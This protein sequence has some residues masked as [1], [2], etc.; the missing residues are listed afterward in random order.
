MQIKSARSQ[1]LHTR[2]FDINNLSG[3]LIDL[4]LVFLNL[5]I[6]VIFVLETYPL[7]P[8]FKNLLWML[9]VFTICFFILEYILRFYTSQNRLRYFFSIYSF[10]DLLVIIPTLI[11]FAFPDSQAS[12]N[13]RVLYLLRGFKVFRIF[14]F[15]R[16]LTDQYFFFGAISLSFLKVLRLI[17]TIIMIFFFGSGVFYYL[18]F[19]NNPG[20]QN[21]GDAFYFC[22]VTLTTVGFGDITPKTAGGKWATVLMIISGI[23]LIPWQASQVVK[24]W[25]FLS[26]KTLT[27]CS[28]C[29]LKY[30]DRDAVHCKHC[31]SPIYQEYEGE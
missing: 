7:S 29:G 16:S 9:E 21:F 5:I 6:C 4:F 22:V 19:G 27:V 10:I 26:S 13:F 28:K 31:G 3:K 18:E 20:V 17:T 1:T 14:R 15:L 11:L 24:E 25:I 23:M 12:E 8:E 30:H 2:L